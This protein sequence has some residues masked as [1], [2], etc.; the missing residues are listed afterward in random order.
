MPDIAA[1]LV[2]KLSKQAK[3]AGTMR[4]DLEPGIIA[5]VGR[6]ES[7]YY[8]VYANFY[9]LLFMGDIDLCPGC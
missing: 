3:E 8:V 9:S 5:S 4:H 7:S 2:S 1:T 6:L